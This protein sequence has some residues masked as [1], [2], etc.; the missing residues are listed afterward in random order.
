MLWIR[1][2]S[3]F[4][5]HVSTITIKPH[6]LLVASNKRLLTSDH[7]F[8]ILLITL[9][10]KSNQ[11]SVGLERKLERHMI[12]RELLTSVLPTISPNA[13]QV[14]T[15]SASVNRTPTLF[16]ALMLKVT[17]VLFLAFCLHVSSYVLLWCSYSYKHTKKYFLS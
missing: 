8:D 4:L 5:V 10:L 17:T 2:V 15:R 13:I 3:F 14:I 7:L 12:G 16:M 1:H 11:V 6:Y 9:I